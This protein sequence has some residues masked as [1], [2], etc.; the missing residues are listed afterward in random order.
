MIEKILFCC[1]SEYVNSKLLPPV[2]EELENYETPDS[3]LSDDVLP[4]S[5]PIAQPFYDQSLLLP[6]TSASNGVMSNDARNSSKFRSQLQQQENNKVVDVF[7]KPHVS[8]VH[9]KD[10]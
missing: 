4:N 8:S 10:F 1:I 5:K 6:T 3:L 2:P 9:L 7:A